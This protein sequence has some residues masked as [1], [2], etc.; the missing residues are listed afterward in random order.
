MYE[1]LR[2]K[3]ESSLIVETTIS[4][5]SAHV[6]HHRALFCYF[7]VVIVTSDTLISRNRVSTAL[8]LN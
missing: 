8:T 2:V 3:E 6:R 7:I 1:S 5:H 4:G